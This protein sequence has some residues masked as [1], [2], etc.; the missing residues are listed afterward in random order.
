MKLVQ[1]SPFRPMSSCVAEESL[2]LAK[3][4]TGGVIEVPTCIVVHSDRG[5]DRPVCVGAELAATHRLQSDGLP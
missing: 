1:T 3:S 5:A 4:F 2:Q